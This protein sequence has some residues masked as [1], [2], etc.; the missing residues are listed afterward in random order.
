[1]R[2]RSLFIFVA[3]IAVGAVTVGLLRHDSTESAE[4]RWRRAAGTSVRVKRFC[5]QFNASGVRFDCLYYV[6]HEDLP[7]PRPGSFEAILEGNT[8]ERPD[9]FEGALKKYLPP[10]EA[11]P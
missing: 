9:P 3:G 1:M 7:S 4:S 10:K 11:T 6:R 5:D 8:D 2:L